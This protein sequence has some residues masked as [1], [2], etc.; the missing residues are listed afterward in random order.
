MSS[1]SVRGIPTMNIADDFLINEYSALIYIYKGLYK[2]KA[3]IP[4]LRKDELL[5]PPMKVDPHI[6][7]RWR[8]IPVGYEPL[9]EKTLLPK[10]CF[11]DIFLDKC[12]DEYLNEVEIPREPIGES[13][14]YSVESVD[15]AISNALGISLM[16]GEMNLREFINV[17]A[18][19]PQPGQIFVG[20]PIKGHYIFGKVI[21]TNVKTRASNCRV[22]KPSRARIRPGD[23]FVVQPHGRE[24]VFGRV[25]KADASILGGLVYLVYI[26]N[27]F[28][29]DKTDI[30]RLDKNNLLIPPI[31]TDRSGW[32][33]GICETVAQMP[34]TKD[35]ILP[36]HCFMNTARPPRYFD[37]H[38]DPLRGC[39]QPCGKHALELERGID[40]LITDA[41]E[42]PRN[43]L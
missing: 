20:E 14:I 24:Y 25:I 19:M 40:A 4:T 29:K 35:D 1:A 37:E 10:H 36:N 5:L 16:N 11:Y 27:A 39:T 12:Y 2:S 31:L 7:G 41:L 28:A 18:E 3:D 22:I 38:D 9:N 13:R 32:R 34:L 17:R 33:S 23:I 43:W 6:W 15:K 26:Y 8:F 21:L 30:P 42:L